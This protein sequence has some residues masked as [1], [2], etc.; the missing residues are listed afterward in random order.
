MSAAKKIVWVTQTNAKPD[1]RE[2]DLESALQVALA[3]A[4]DLAAE[5]DFVLAQVLAA[6]GKVLATVGPGGSVHLP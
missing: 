3:R 1:F 4:R 2:L 6:D 5:P